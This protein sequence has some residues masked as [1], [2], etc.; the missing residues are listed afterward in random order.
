MTEQEPFDWKIEGDIV[1]LPDRVLVC[2]MEYGSKV[3]K[4]GIIVMSDDG[5][6]RGIH[7]RWATVY[8]VGKN[9]DYINKGDKVLVSHGRWS[10]G[11]SVN[12]GDEIVVVRM[13]EPESILGV[14]SETD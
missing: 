4:G 8:S 6:E 3:T 2:D 14:M 1:P 12:N 5:K 7:P 13:V 10:R 9:V 11:V